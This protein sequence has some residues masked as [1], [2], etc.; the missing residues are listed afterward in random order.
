M[1][2][3]LSPRELEYI[4]LRA[5]GLCIKR[6]AIRMGISTNTVDDYAKRS[7]LKLGAKTT[8]HAVALAVRA[9]IA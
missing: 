5:A 9:G 8:A 6:I 3:Q 7:R 4:Q 2:E 1:T